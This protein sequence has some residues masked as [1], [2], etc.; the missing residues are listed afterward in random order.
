MKKTVS[1]FLLILFAFSAVSCSGNENISVT[2]GFSVAGYG[3][4]NKAVDFSVIYPDTWTVTEDAGIVSLRFDCDPSDTTTSFAGIN[5]MAFTLDDSE[6][7]AVKYWE[8]YS[9]DIEKTYADYAF[10][11]KAEITLD[12][13][14][15]LKVK[16]NASV[17]DA[18]YTFAQVI[19]VRNGKVYLITLSAKENDFES[20]SADFDTVCKEFLFV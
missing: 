11:D 17:N 4:G 1:V 18:K 13:T 19:C 2:D 15:A 7:G 14:A 8:D 6:T 9:K 10:L 3:A 5:F 16:Y 12:N 20:V